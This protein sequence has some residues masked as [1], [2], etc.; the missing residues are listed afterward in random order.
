[1]KKLREYDY[2]RYA[3]EFWY[4]YHEDSESYTGT[5]YEDA[6]H[7]YICE[8]LQCDNYEV[9]NVGTIRI[10]RV[11][12][13]IPNFTN[14]YIGR[15]KDNPLG[16]PWPITYTDSR[17]CVCD[18]YD[19]WLEEKV[20]DKS[21]SQY[22]EMAKLYCYIMSGVNINLQCFCTPNRC[23]GETIVRILMR[24]VNKTFE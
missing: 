7:K 11:H 1:M 8:C 2:Q 9:V 19:V 23:H 10:G 14:Y 16:N 6:L 18:K 21:S 13:N 5:E 24:A 22:K 20:K 17:D 4:Q 3:T 12:E 15:G